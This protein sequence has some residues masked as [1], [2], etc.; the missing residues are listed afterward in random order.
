MSKV[1]LVSLGCDKNRVDGEV[2]I[3][4]L[5]CGGYHVINNPE[6]ADA[7][8]VNTCGFIR[9][10]VQE[11][12]DLILDLASYKD[13]GLCRALIVVGCMAARYKDEILESIPEIDA[14]L[15][16]GEYETIPN[17]IRKFVPPSEINEKDIQANSK[18]LRMA[19]R[20]DDVAPHI[21]YVK[22]SEGCNNHCTYCT[23]PSIRGA[24][25][26]RP[27]EDII[28]ECRLLISLGTREL[29]LVAQDTALYGTDIYN[30]KKL[31]ELIRHVAAL[32]EKDEEDKNIRI[33]LMYAYPEH[34]TPELIQVM[35]TLPQVC[36]YIDMPIQHSEDNILASMGRDSTKEKLLSL[37]SVLREKIPN[38][39]IRTTLMVGFPG[40]T[41]ENFLN[42]YNFVKEIKFD[43][44]GVFPYSQEEGTPAA[45]FLNQV[46]E[47]VKQARLD[48][49]MTLQQ[50]I[51]FAKQNSL[52]G[53]IIPIIVDLLPEKDN[54]YVGRTQWDAYE[55]D[56]VVYFSV[57]D[58]FTGNLPTVGQ[59]CHIHITNTDQYD[60]L[61]VL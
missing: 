51:H 52:V 55:V 18:F 44:M 19:A 22:I 38:I 24:Y 48:S 28:E 41:D 30:E 17:V 49:L 39:A 3:G 57:S 7:I 50:E 31:P 43:R 45:T 34:I 13:E 9:E 42:M 32:E 15:G 2:M 29:I 58:G 40:E 35:A 26:S 4:S 12:I 1:Y 11:S 10:A 5:R 47:E 8:I 33:R 14:I 54:Y 56:S 61:G 16:V 46:D 23:I 20:H 36:K 27:F 25:Q 37:I 6:N 59:V 21:A 60:L 53:Q